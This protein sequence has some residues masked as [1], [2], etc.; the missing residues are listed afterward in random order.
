MVAES[1]KFDLTLTP[2]KSDTM[3]SSLNPD[4][5]LF[6]PSSANLVTDYLSDGNTGDFTTEDADTLLTSPSPL[7]TD[8]KDP[9]DGFVEL[10]SDQPEEVPFEWDVDD[11]SPEWWNL[12]HTSS[13]FREFWMRGYE[14]DGDHILPEDDVHCGNLK[15]EEKQETEA[16]EKQEIPASESRGVDEEAVAEMVKSIEPNGSVT[17]D[18]L[19]KEN[20]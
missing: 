12:V 14:F 2:F 13:A 10:F 1:G 19:S 5:P 20:H 4:A 9:C 16:E 18:L 8:T 7:N 6:Q 17:K 15:V 3:S 11:F